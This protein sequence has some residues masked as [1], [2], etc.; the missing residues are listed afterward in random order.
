MTQFKLLV[1]VC[2]C[3]SAHSLSAQFVSLRGTHASQMLLNNLYEADMSHAIGAELVYSKPVQ[4]IKWPLSYNLGVDY[5]NVDGAH[6]GYLIT[7][8]TW[9]T[10]TPSGFM[11]AP[12]AESVSYVTSNWLQYATVNM[13]NG[14]LIGDSTAIYS[15]GFSLD[16]NFGY[17]FGKQFFVHWGLGGRYN[18]TPSYAAELNEPHSSFD[19]ML[20]AGFLWKF[21][22]KYGNPNR[23]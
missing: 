2:L 16:Y 23:K 20:K 6:S 5:R 3:L 13:Y 17:V 22:K 10:R 11:F 4:F 7:G 12:N 8:I 15:M 19:F 1:F 21:K 9:V 18:I 14:A